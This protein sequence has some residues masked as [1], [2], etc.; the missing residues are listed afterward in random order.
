MNCS[1]VRE[2]LYE[3][4]FDLLEPG[5]RRRVAEHLRSCPRCSGELEELRGVLGAWSVPAAPAGLT[6]RALAR[7]EA[8]GEPEP[9]EVRE[10]G[11]GW[12]WVVPWVAA[13]GV[14]AAVLLSV[15]GIYL[16]GLRPEPQDTVVVAPRRLLLPGPMAASPGRAAVR[17]MVRTGGP[18]GWYPVS[19]ARGTLDLV[20]RDS[21]RPFYHLCQFTTDPDGSAS[22]G[23]A[24]RGLLLEADGVRT[25]RYLL[26][27]GV[28]S[29]HGSDWVALPVTLQR[30]YRLLLDTDQPLYRP[31]Q[32]VRVRGVLLDAQTLQP[33]PDAPL[34]LA[35]LDD[36]GRTL[37]TRNTR[38]SHWGLFSTELTLPEGLS[39]GTYRLVASSAGSAYALP[40]R[41]L[42]LPTES[43]DGAFPTLEVR[44]RRTWYRPGEEVEVL[45]RVR[46]SQGKPPAGGRLEVRAAVGDRPLGPASAVETDSRGEA[47]VRLPLPR[48]LP[49]GAGEGSAAVVRVEARLPLGGGSAAVG[50]AFVGVAREPLRVTVRP[51]AGVLVP[52][53]Q[54]RLYVLV[55]RPDGSPTEAHLALRT[56]TG[57]ELQADTDRLG[58]AALTFTPTEAGLEGTLT[59]E[60]DTGRRR[61][62]PL[63][64]PLP[65]PAPRV[66]VRPERWYVPADEPIRVTVL[67]PKEAAS[68]LVDVGINGQLALTESVALQEGVGRLDITLPRTETEFVGLVEVRSYL[69][70][71]GPAGSVARRVCVGPA[72]RATLRAE[73]LGPG[74]GKGRR[75]RLSLAGLEDGEGP[76]WFSVSVSSVPEGLEPEPSRWLSRYLMGP[77]A[78]PE[79]ALRAWLEPRALSS[80]IET[81]GGGVPP[82]EADRLALALLG[83]GSRLLPQAP[84]GG[85]RQGAPGGAAEGGFEVRHTYPER[86]AA[87]ARR[88]ARFIPLVRAGLWTVS[89]GLLM[90]GLVSLAAAFGGAEEGRWLGGVFQAGLCGAVVAAVVLAVLPRLGSLEAYREAEAQAAA[91][92]QP[93]VLVPAPAPIP[94][95]GETP[96]ALP[97]PR[98]AGTLPRTVLWAP[99]ACTDTP[100]VLE[101]ELPRAS[102]EGPLRVSVFALVPTGARG[103]TLSGATFL[104]RG[105]GSS[106]TVALLP[107][108]LM[109]ELGLTR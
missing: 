22:V 4:H 65:S 39:Q 27:L 34:T 76:S 63:R 43:P 96:L 83:V 45:L 41:V 57:L 23:F 108:R 80:L 99:A 46:D 107:Y 53:V 77:P 66:L 13:A 28:L 50:E 62:V 75:L 25:D 42:D 56:E 84:T 12:R 35:L 78:G 74:G 88:Q 17:V 72:R 21:G 1:E 26:A 9:A 100:G 52:G 29:E 8:P 59:V 54:N 47:V 102:A 49:G 14:L 11:P 51:E 38:C 19:G 86:A 105:E 104:L 48:V 101:L 16:T 33:Q 92:A 109:W 15:A 82:P 81:D 70:E 7:A 79:Q 3:Y 71:D 30:A 18:A 20:E 67:G 95:P 85:A 87:V 2:L 31:G 69:P 5:Q 103:Y 68:A 64:L 90:V 10:P 24:L 44:T 36:R 60:D 97:S 61:E 37:T 73:V 91:Q 89:V 58:L 93:Q 32:R 106:R 55:T 94:S 40:L 98:L 6:E